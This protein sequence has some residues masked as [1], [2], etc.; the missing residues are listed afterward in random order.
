MEDLQRQIT[1]L[2]AEID[3]LKSSTTI[4]FDIGGAFEERI[5]AVKGDTSSETPT[6]HTQAV[7]EG[8]TS[9]YNVAKPMDGFITITVNNI[10]RKIPY[11]D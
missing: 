10:P 1:E 5:G 4:P 6:S 7:D 9:T 8:G 2:K 3:S 11:Y